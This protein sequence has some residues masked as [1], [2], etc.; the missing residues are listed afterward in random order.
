MSWLAKKRIVIIGGTSGIGLSAAHAFIREGAT[1]LVVGRDKEKTVLA[2]SELGTR[3]I[4]FA[5]D[6]SHENT[7]A[8]AIA[9]CVNK[10][11]GFDGLYHVAGG[12]GRKFGDGPLHE[13]MVY[14]M[15]PVVV[16]ESLVTDLYMN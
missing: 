3:A 16:E 14:I 4:G 12:S 6:A 2:T 13:L 9:L 1:V 8:E 11:G 5:G 10:L 15:L 7:A